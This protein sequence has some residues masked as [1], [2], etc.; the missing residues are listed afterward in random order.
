M[1][2]IVIGLTAAV[3]LVAVVA[4]VWWYLDRQAAEAKLLRASGILEATEVRLGSEYGGRVVA[5]PAREGDPV[6]HGEM[7]VRFDTEVLEHR[8]QMADTGERIL[9]EHQ[10][11]RQTL[12]APF[13]GWVVRTVFEVG[14]NA[15][16]GVPAVVVADW[17][18]LTLKVYLPE[19]RFGRVAMNQRAEITVDAY[20]NERFSG[21]VTFIASQAEFAP[22][23][24]QTREDRIKSVYAIKL[25]VPNADLRLKPGMFADATFGGVGF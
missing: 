7:L 24:L 4:G 2:N 20:P 23:N 15:P 13:D 6:R 10:K 18:E 17:R 22:R 14:E 11:E 16:P 8:I 1:K 19:D 5:R 3:A 25:R 9:L 21:V 12:T